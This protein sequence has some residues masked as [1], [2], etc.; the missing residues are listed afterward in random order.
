MQT[1]T[2]QLIG[3]NLSNRM[4]TDTLLAQIIEGS[5]QRRY[6]LVSRA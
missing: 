4:L 5:K 6:H 2:K 3:L 1:L